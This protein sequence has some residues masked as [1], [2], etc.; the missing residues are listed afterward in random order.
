LAYILYKKQEFFD[1]KYKKSVLENTRY[2]FEA[3]SMTA[4]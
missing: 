3:S 1:N 2:A 4:L